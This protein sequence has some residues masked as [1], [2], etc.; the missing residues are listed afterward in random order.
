MCVIL[1]AKTKRLSQ[2]MVEQAM[3]VNPHGNG[4]AWMEGKGK[5]R[6][7]R[8]E[9]GLNRREAL[10]FLKEHPLP[11]PYVFHARIAS[12]GS[13][14]AKLTH[15]FPICTRDKQLR[16]SGSTRKGVVFHNG[17]WFDW[18]NYYRNLEEKVWSD[19]RAMADLMHDFGPEIVEE[20]PESQQ[21]AIMTPEGVTT[22]GNRWSEVASGVLASNRFFLPVAVTPRINFKRIETLAGSGP[23]LAKRIW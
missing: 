2:K 23:G 14:C 11:M 1:F 9:K 19:T 6:T 12:V 21:L 3:D 13:V 20:I 18:E 5:Q 16:L 17:T 7:V 4:F 8:F 15:P 22:L 10:K